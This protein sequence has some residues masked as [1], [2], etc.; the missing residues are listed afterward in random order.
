METGTRIETVL[1]VDITKLFTHL[2]RWSF[3][4]FQNL[5]E[6][7]ILTDVFE[8]ARQG[9]SFDIEK[10]FRRFRELDM[11]NRRHLF[12]SGTVSL[13]QL[14]RFLNE[15]P[16]KTSR[17]WDATM[18]V[19]KAWSLTSV[20]WNENT[21]P[22]HVRDE[23]REVMGLEPHNLR[24]KKGEKE[25][26][27]KRVKPYQFYHNK[28]KPSSP[29]KGFRIASLED[30]KSV[31]VSKVEYLVLLLIGGEIRAFDNQGYMPATDTYIGDT[32]IYL[33]LVKE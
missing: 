28:E 32:Y 12:D 24:F 22:W 8:A 19:F 1:A 3:R 4:G 9:G 23:W 33:S 27:L 5:T 7:G 31:A 13:S 17:S 21:I 2:K 29:P 15:A 30:C 26:Y 11:S 20:W 18:R 14:K 6:S 10:L 16:T 25:V